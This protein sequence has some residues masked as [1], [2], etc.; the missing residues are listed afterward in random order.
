LMASI[1]FPAWCL[2]HDPSAQILSVSYAQD[3]ADKLARDCRSI[4]TSDPL[5]IDPRATVGGLIEAFEEVLDLGLHLGVL[6]APGLHEDDPIGRCSGLR[7]RRAPSIARQPAWAQAQGRPYCPAAA[8]LRIRAVC[9][10][11]GALQD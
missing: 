7:N 9:P 4:M 5:P 1:A 8:I 10:L 3:L 2:G 11:I 6:H